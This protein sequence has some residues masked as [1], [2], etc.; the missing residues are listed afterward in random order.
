M[1]FCDLMPH[2]SLD[3][4]TGALI[5]RT[6]A[7]VF[8]TG[9]N[10]SRKAQIFENNLMTHIQCSPDKSPLAILYLSFVNPITV[11]TNHLL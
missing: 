5:K 8:L 9:Y 1:W 4:Q 2:A 11:T 10:S 7:G 6:N 3:L